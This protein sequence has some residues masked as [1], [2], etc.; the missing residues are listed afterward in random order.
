MNTARGGHGM[1][2]YNGKEK[3]KSSVYLRRARARWGVFEAK[4]KRNLAALRKA[5]ICDDMVKMSPP[6]IQPF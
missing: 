4:L 2:V 1:A 5:I 3:S 6:A